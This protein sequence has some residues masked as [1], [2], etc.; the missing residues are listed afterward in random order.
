MCGEHYQEVDSASRLQQMTQA[1]RISQAIHAAAVLSIADLMGDQTCGI[2][3][4][5]LWAGCDLTSL[6]RL[7]RALA[8]AGVF[9]ELDGDRFANNDL[10]A[11]LRSDHPRSVR[12]SAVFIGQPNHWETW[13]TLVHAVRTGENA[14]AARYGSDVWSYR[15]EHPDQNV[16]F[17]ATMASNTALLATALVDAYDFSAVSTV[18]DVGGGNGALLVAVLD[19]NPHLRG[20]VFDQPHV[21]EAARGVVAGVAF[22][23]RCALVPGSFFE[24]VPT[25]ADLYVLKSIVHDWGDEDSVAIL[26]RCREAMSDTAVLLLM[27]RLLE[28]PNLGLEVKFSDL[29]MMV[30]PGG[31]ERTESEY[32]AL[33]GAAGLSLRRTFRP[34]GP[35]AILEAVRT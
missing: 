7:L 18:V 2:D 15:A 14:F 31:R 26:R 13:G 23:D 6:R 3:D 35:I 17:D 4:L 25:G 5:A 30:M 20:T 10:S 34:D 1:F 21:I 33:L 9:T 32:A 11:P 12:A 24:A 28:G 16:I 27:E 8:A 22:A 29:N 19:A